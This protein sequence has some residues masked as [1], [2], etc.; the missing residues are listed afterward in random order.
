M[1]SLLFQNLY[2]FL[3]QSGSKTITFGAAHTY[4][5]Y[6]GVAPPPGRIVYKS[7]TLHRSCIVYKP[8]IVLRSQ[9]IVADVTVCILNVEL[10]SIN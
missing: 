8:R 9:A 2:P 6:I 1:Q 5:A 7:R 3:D 10:Y 4:L